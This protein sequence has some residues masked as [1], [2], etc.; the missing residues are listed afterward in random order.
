MDG[1]ACFLVE[2]ETKVA[3]S[4]RTANSALAKKKSKRHFDNYCLFALVWAGVALWP[5]PCCTERAPIN[6]ILKAC[7]AC[8]SA[9]CPAL[10]PP[11][12]RLPSLVLSVLFSSTLPPS[13][14]PV[15]PPCST[16]P[17]PKPAPC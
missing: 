2:R 3:Q 16:P 10:P 17:P 7:R 1:P 8:S 15:A 4:R 12:P 11:P 6:A 13:F 5:L 14:A 9:P